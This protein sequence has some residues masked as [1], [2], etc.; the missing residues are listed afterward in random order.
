MHNQNEGGLFIRPWGR[1]CTQKQYK[2]GDF[3]AISVT[4]RSWATPT[5]KVE[6]DISE[7]FCVTLSCSVNGREDWN[8]LRQK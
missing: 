7:K 2:N 8:P 4:D 3:G 6:R 5:L 1:G